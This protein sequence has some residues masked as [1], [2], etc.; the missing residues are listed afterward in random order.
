[1]Q[2]FERKLLENSHFAI[3]WVMGPDTTIDMG[4]T[5]CGERR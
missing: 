3:L 1:M 4:E 5:D 2:D